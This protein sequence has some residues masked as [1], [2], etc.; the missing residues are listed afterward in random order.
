MVGIT[1]RALSERKYSRIIIG[2]T[3]YSTARYF[4]FSSVK[5]VHRKFFAFVTTAPH[6][7]IYTLKRDDI[8]HFG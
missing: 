5:N 7:V 6:P 2:E 8:Q 1:L 4:C 3:P